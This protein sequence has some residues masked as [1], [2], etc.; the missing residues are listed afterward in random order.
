[1]S[2]LVLSQLRSSSLRRLLSFSGEDASPA[3]V[4]KL[5]KNLPGLGLALDLCS[6]LLHAHMAC[7]FWAHG[8]GG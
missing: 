7:D 1:V 6:W 4:A 5:S 2:I 8:D 3:E